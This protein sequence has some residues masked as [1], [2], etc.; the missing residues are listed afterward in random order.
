[1]VWTLAT[2]YDFS[3]C[4]DTA[5]T[6]PLPYGLINPGGWQIQ[7]GQLVGP[8]YG[9]TFVF[10]VSDNAR[11]NIFLGA[12][13][14][15][16]VQLGLRYNPST[17]HAY[18][19]HVRQGGIFP[20]FYGGGF[21]GNAISYSTSNW[22]GILSYSTVSPAANITNLSCGTL[23]PDYSVENNPTTPS[24]TNTEFQSGQGQRYFAI[25]PV[26]TLVHIS[27]IEYYTY[28][29]DPVV[30]NTISANDPKIRANRIEWFVDADNSILTNCS[31]AEL[32]LSWTGKELHIITQKYSSGTLYYYTFDSA[33]GWKTLQLNTAQDPT[34]AGSTSD[35]LESA[36]PAS[37]HITWIRWVSPANGTRWNFTDSSTQG[38]RI[39]ILNFQTDGT[40]NNYSNNN[41]FIPSDITIYFGDSITE[42]LFGD[43]TQP[44][45]VT[46]AQALNSQACIVGFGAQGWNVAGL[47]DIPA[48]KDAW[49]FYWSN[50]SRL[51]NGKFP[52]NIKRIWINHGTNDSGNTDPNST[53]GFLSFVI[54]TLTAIYAALPDPTTEIVLQVPFGGYGRGT[55]KAAYQ[56]LI[57]A[58]PTWN[59]LLVD[60]GNQAAIGLDQKDSVHIGNYMPSSSWYAVDGLHLTGS[61]YYRV[62]TLILGAYYQAK[63][64]KTA[65]QSNTLSPAQPVLSHF[66]KA[67]PR[68]RR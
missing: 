43:G 11:I 62:A 55:L 21:F 30:L 15:D 68:G 16:A 23:N 46:V 51:I 19:M 38:R 27:K 1:M 20:F 53:E 37:P 34:G 12:N 58:N 63:Q 52:E 44:W 7:N 17:G 40:F 48:F 14:S 66:S 35:L 31:D 3:S 56:Q 45:E 49:N 29:P 13:S 32:W 22:H 4:A 18:G 57:T 60:A 61:N 8:V 64:A 42:Q 2:T 33:S 10:S 24:D 47:G 28:T 65:T 41:R 5:T 39:N 25:R 54:S 26:D 9:S 50:Q 59:L 6:D 67:L 36:L